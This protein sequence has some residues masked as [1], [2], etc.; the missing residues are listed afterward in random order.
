MSSNPI[1]ATAQPLP[2]AQLLAHIAERHGSDRLKLRELSAR[3]RDRAW[4]GMLLIFAAVN[5]LPL[6]PGTTT[7][8]GI[9]LII[10]TAQMAWGRRRPW[11][12][13][14]LDDR[15]IGKPLL[16]K[17]AA[18]MAPWEQR[19]GRVLKPR[20]CWLTNHRGTRV[21]GAVGLA[22]SAILWLPIP[23]GNHAPALALTLFALALLYRD[24]MLVIAGFVAT[25]A[26][27]VL[28]SLTF[29]A[30][31]WAAVQLWAHTFGAS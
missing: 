23:L 29:A 6:P 15:G 27:L 7:V 24:G 1:D 2:F 11:F 13:R 30:A 14:K 3:L 10:I 20:L 31:W 26:S 22:L 12:P 19:I 5:L 21:I 17:V 4:G 18:K 25:I 8:T 16:S 9:P 28:V